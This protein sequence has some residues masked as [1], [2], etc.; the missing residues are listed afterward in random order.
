[1]SA[2]Q[3]KASRFCLNSRLSEWFPVLRSGAE[4][5]LTFS[6]V[7]IGRRSRL[8]VGL[9]LRP[10]SKSSVSRWGEL[11]LHTCRES[12]Q[13]VEVPSNSFPFGQFWSP[14]RLLGNPRR[15][16]NRSLQQVTWLCK[17]AALK[18]SWLC[19]VRRLGARTTRLPFS[20]AWRQRIGLSVDKL[21]IWPRLCRIRSALLLLPRRF[22]HSREHIGR[23]LSV[24]SSFQD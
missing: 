12:R 24:F 2:N 15:K 5:L 11:Y 7:L 1:M 16:G 14:N 4:F 3:L 18:L 19:S 17:L 23:T 9:L 22:A 13:S 6:S 21:R 20:S 8:L 10:A